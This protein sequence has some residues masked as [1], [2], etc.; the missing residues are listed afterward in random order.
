M[1][2][3]CQSVVANLREGVSN[4]VDV[5]QDSLL[6]RNFVLMLNTSLKNA[7]YLC[8]DCGDHWGSQKVFSAQLLLDVIS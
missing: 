6:R 5:L 4:N 7:T 1:G 8:C 2:A 3:G